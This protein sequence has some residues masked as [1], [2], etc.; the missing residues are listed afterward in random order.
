M[1]KW[2]F[3]FIA[4]FSLFLLSACGAAEEPEQ[5]AS[6][7]GATT[8]KKWDSPPEMQIDPNKAYSATIAT[9]KGDIKIELFSKDA[10]Q[11]VNN[12]VFLAKEQFY[13]N[14]LFHRIMEGF[15][16]QTG[17][18]T[19]T[20]AGG[21][22]YQFADELPSPHK[23]EKGIVAMANAGPNTNGS[24]FFICN[25]ADSESLNA[26]PNYTIFGRVIEGMETVEAISSVSVKNNP[27][28]GE[29]SQPTEEIYIKDITITES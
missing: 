14:V 1:K 21:P 6:D 16:I 20:G 4:S 10:P 15:M 23:Y 11:T 5:A 13:Q 17:D 18:P 24:Q 25:G 8:T 29:P 22:G 3:L 26:H 12:F 19:G 2:F 7:R 9:N 27:A 28:T